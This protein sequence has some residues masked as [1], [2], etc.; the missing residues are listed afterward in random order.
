[1]SRP[2]CLRGHPRVLPGSRLGRSCRQCK[3]DRNR[4]PQ[5]RVYATKANARWRS[6]NP[7][8]GRTYKLGFRA[9]RRA[10]IRAARQAGWRQRPSGAWCLA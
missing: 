1:V 2:E 5:Y 4:T 9:G 6:K 8:Y 3:A 10:A 7:M